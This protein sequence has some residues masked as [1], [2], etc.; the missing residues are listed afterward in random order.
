M[1]RAVALQAHLPSDTQQ[2]VGRLLEGLAPFNL[3]NMIDFVPAR[4]VGLA[5]LSAPIWESRGRVL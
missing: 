4:P 1:D 3:H 5:R 2:L